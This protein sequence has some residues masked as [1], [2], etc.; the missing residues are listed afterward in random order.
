MGTSTRIEKISPFGFFIFSSEGAGGGVS[1]SFFLGRTMLL[2]V[3]G[4]PSSVVGWVGVWLE[5]VGVV[6]VG[7]VGF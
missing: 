2:S 7:S 6:G 1:S 3:V 5:G 4:P